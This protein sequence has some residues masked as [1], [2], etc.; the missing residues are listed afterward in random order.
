[1]R[2]TVVKSAVLASLIA[3]AT[4]VAVSSLAALGAHGRAL[5]AADAG[6][7]RASLASAASE[8]TAEVQMSI[9]PS[10]TV[11]A[12]GESFTVA[13]VIEDAPEIR[14]YEFR[15][16]WNPAVFSV[17]TAVDAGFLSTPP[18]TIY[19]PYI[20][21]DTLSFGAGQFSTPPEF[22]SGEGVLAIV[23]LLATGVG[24]ST[25][26]LYRTR[27]FTRSGGL[28]GLIRISDPNDGMAE[29]V[30]Q[31]AEIEELAAESPVALGEPTA[32]TATLQ[33]ATPISTTWDFDDDGT[34]ERSGVGL[35]AVTHTYAAT[36]TYTAALT[37]NN[38]CGVEDTERVTV[39]VEEAACGPVQIEALSADP[40]VIA[41]VPA[42]FTATV[43]GS[44]PITYNWDFD[45]DGSPDQLGE[46][47]DGVTHTY[48][49]AG[50]YTVTLTA[51][52]GC[53]SQA[54][55]TLTGTVRCEEVTIQGLSSDSPVT[56]GEPMHFTATV[57]GTQP[58]TYSWDFGDEDAGEGTGRETATPTW[59]YAATGP[60]TVT[61]Q[62]DNRC[63]GPGDEAMEPVQVVPYRIFLPLILRSS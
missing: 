54:R 1:M 61:L 60:Y 52:N 32:F 12:P 25:L 20:S 24:T 29:S 49:T 16:T 6:E 46:G 33:G 18:D 11:V 62:V 40:E 48:A 5:P 58:Y 31:A 37:V 15:M 57:I 17:T 21:T 42:H 51:E 39:T 45:G 8:R 7:D 41:G 22:A 10:R 56:I 14:S 43:S 50:P 47:L 36:G 4:V 3:C 34:P 53:P 2:R 19:G 30:C 13:V 44:R 38:V 9:Q 63:A 26:D 35:D 27:V 59:I 23:E 55:E 28:E